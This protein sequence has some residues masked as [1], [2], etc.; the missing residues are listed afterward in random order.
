M[1]LWFGENGD[2]LT[3]VDHRDEETARRW[4]VESAVGKPYRPWFRA[5]FA[6]VLAQRGPAPQRIL[7]LGSG[8][9]LLAER[10]LRDV[11]VSEYVLFDFSEA[12]MRMAREA[13][14]P[15]TDVTCHVGDFKSDDWHL[16]LDGP[17]D[18]IISMQAV[19]EIRHKR[20][21]PLLYSRVKTL[22]RRGGL[23]L[24]CDHEP[25]ADADELKR[26]LAS[27]RQEQEQAML[28]ADLG[29]VRCHA[30]EHHCYLMSATNSLST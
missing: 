9:G 11:A 27:S 1:A 2:V 17:F 15:R 25:A 18:A 30:F 29:N 24:I 26:Q 12:M 8:P 10:V 4:A 5:E 3:T 20:H 7:E 13:L 6:R 22:L 16:G 14:G 23:L 21:V 19:H 28:S